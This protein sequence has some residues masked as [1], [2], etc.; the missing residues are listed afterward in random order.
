VYAFLPNGSKFSPPKDITKWSFF[1]KWLHFYQ[2]DQ[3][4]VYQMTLPNGHFLP[5]GLPNGEPIW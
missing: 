5:N 4:P 3:N 2:M 1:T